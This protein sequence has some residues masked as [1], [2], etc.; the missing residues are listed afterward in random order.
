L[1]INAISDNE[2][3]FVGF[4]SSS[5]PVHVW[6]DLLNKKPLKEAALWKDTLDSASPGEFSSYF[7]R[8]PDIEGQPLEIYMTEASLAGNQFQIDWEI[9]P[10][11]QYVSWVAVDLI[12]SRGWFFRESADNPNFG[13]T[14]GLPADW[15]S[16]TLDFEAHE[17]DRPLLNGQSFLQTRDEFQRRYHTQTNFE[18]VEELPV[19]NVTTQSPFL[20]YQTYEDANQNKFR[21]NFD[22]TELGLPAQDVITTIRLLN[23]TNDSEVPVERFGFAEYF[24]WT[25]RSM[26]EPVNE[27]RPIWD[28]YYGSGYSVFFHPGTNIPLGEYQYVAE[29]GS[30]ETIELPPITF[31][32]PIALPVVPGSSMQSE[33]VND[34]DLRLSWQSPAVPEPYQTQTAIRIWVVGGDAADFNAIFSISVRTDFNSVTIPKRMLENAKITHPFEDASWRVELRYNAQGQDQARSVSNWHEIQDWK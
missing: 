2:F 7:S 34:G 25:N 21:S 19:S 1:D 20:Q 3:I 16:T 10:L 31:E 4:D 13:D 14:A 33:W 29:T 17:L 23:L 6:I 30:G 8:R 12:D 9:A 32:G 5:N 28:Q 26:N 15:T 24:W 22:L 18:V 11:G 27:L